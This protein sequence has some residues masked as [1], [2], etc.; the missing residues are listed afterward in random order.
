MELKKTP[1]LITGGGSGLGAATA[2]LL[3]E[4]GAKVAVLDRNMEAAKNVAK[5]ISG[6]AVECDVTSEDSVKAAL[7]TAAKTQGV[8]RVVVNCAGILGAGRI[9]GRE[10]PMALSFF[11]QVLCVNLLGTFNVLR[12]AAEAM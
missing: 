1:V 4:A 5:D 7:A 3:A 10:A 8:A 2:R 11:D 9:L 6:L 12:L